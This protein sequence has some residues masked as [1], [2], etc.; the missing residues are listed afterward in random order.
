[1]IKLF[2]RDEV[3]VCTPPPR[4]GRGGAYGA[5]FLFR[6]DLVLSDLDLYAI[7]IP[8][9]AESAEITVRPSSVSITMKRVVRVN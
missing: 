9:R 2:W 8:E 5:D 7:T 4:I 6:Q 1:L 3:G